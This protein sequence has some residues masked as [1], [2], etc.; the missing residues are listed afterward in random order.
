MLFLADTS[1]DICFLDKTCCFI[2]IIFEGLRKYNTFL[3]SLFFYEI[4]D[5][6]LFLEQ[7]LSEI[8]N[9]FENLG[10]LFRKLKKTAVQGGIVVNSNATQDRCQIL[11]TILPCHSLFNEVQLPCLC[12]KAEMRPAK[13]VQLHH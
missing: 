5:I 13:F 12:V 11:V 8:L 6:A 1:K 7:P 10:E 4:L 9:I 2:C 3:F